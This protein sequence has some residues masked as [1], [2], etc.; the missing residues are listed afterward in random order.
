[1]PTTPKIEDWSIRVT[2]PDLM[3]GPPEDHP[4]Q[5]YINKEDIPLAIPRIGQFFVQGM[6]N[7]MGV[8]YHKYGSFHEMFPD[9][10]SGIGNALVRIERYQQT[11]NI[12]DLIDGANYL[13]IEFCRPGIETAYFKPEDSHASPGALNRDGT[14]SHGKD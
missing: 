7:R 12:E 5:D 14:I 6:M 1:M 9:K 10:R 4:L 3:T 2:N 8:S 11:G 13:M